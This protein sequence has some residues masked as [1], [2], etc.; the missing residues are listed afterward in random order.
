MTWLLFSSSTG[1]RCLWEQ[2]LLLRK[3]WAPDRD[4]AHGLGE[5]AFLVC[6]NCGMMEPV[7]IAELLERA[8]D[9]EE[10]DGAASRE[11]AT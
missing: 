1:S 9:A 11:A 4:L 3:L 10:K 7:R 5:R 2:L 6:G 8:V